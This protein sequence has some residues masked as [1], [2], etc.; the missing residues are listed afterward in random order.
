MITVSALNA[1]ANVRHGFF[2]RNGGVSEGIY[3]SR[4]CGFGSNDNPEHVR[5]NRARCM[6]EVELPPE[7]LGRFY[8]EHTSKVLIVDRPSPEGE[9]PVAEAMAC[10]HAGSPEIGKNTP[11]RSICGVRTRVNQ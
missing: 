2:T 4:N 9:S 10:T 6:L 3:A 5:T 8:Q 11:H 7:S 1:L